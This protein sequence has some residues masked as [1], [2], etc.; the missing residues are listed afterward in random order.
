MANPGGSAAI[1]QV[2][3]SIIQMVSAGGDPPVILP[4]PGGLGPSCLVSF[5]SADWFFFFF[6]IDGSFLS[7]CQRL[8]VF[9]L[10]VPL[11][12]PSQGLA[13]LC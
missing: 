12:G 10:S 1:I 2:E 5:W 6:L 7:F 13:L 8:R 3:K 9:V 4:C 11:G